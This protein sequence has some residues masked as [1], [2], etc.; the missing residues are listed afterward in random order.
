MLQNSKSELTGKRL[1]IEKKIFECTLNVHHQFPVISEWG[2]LHR[3]FIAVHTE[4]KSIFG[5]KCLEQDL[6]R[7]V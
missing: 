6:N 7:S 4:N 5:V 1:C 3:K 2:Q